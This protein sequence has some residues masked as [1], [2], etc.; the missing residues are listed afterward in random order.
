L[1]F[2]ST[3]LHIRRMRFFYIKNV[4]NSFRSGFDGIGD[5]GGDRP[6]RSVRHPRHRPALRLQK[7][8][9]LLQR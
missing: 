3:I 1:V 8:K 4:F 2:F 9:A 6:P 5:R 7:T